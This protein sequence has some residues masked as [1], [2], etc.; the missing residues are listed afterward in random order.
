MKSFKSMWLLSV[1]ALGVTVQ[2]IAQETLPMVTVVPVNYK[3]LTSVNGR[4]V[5]Q[6]VN[7]VQL[8]AA[9]FSVKNSEFYEDDYD[10]YFISFY[11]PDGNV[12]AVYDKDGKLLRTVEKFKNV[13]V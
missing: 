3:Y 12:L 13:A 7:L 6:P 10:N 11:I 2:S 9:T 5:A 8:R 1:L 4:Q